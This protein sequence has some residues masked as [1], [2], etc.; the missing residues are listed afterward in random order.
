[1]RCERTGRKRSIE[2]EAKEMACDERE[3]RKRK[4]EMDL[5]KQAGTE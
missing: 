3:C 5:E 4:R 2:Q 1:M